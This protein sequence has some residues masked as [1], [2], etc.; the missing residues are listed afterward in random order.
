ML[1]RVAFELKCRLFDDSVKQCVAVY[2]SALQCVAVCCSVLQCVAIGCSMLHYV[3][4]CCSIVQCVAV[5]VEALLFQRCSNFLKS[6]S[7]VCV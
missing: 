7:P 3:A 4:V 1:Q 6:A 2:C 5:A